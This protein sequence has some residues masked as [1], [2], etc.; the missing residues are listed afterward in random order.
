M[1]VSDASHNIERKSVKVAK[2]G[3][4][5]NI[6]LGFLKLYLLKRNHN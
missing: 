5:K 2:E 1:D 6:P 3:T 4:P